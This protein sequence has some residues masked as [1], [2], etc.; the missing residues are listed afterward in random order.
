MLIKTLIDSFLTPLNCLAVKRRET[1]CS[2]FMP[3]EKSEDTKLTPQEKVA[4]VNGLCSA[5]AEA[6]F[7]GLPILVLF[8]V[9]HYK[10]LDS[11]LLA[12]PEWSFAAAVLFGL[13][14]VKLVGSI[15]STGGGHGERI[16]FLCALLLVLG[17]VPSLIV[18]ALV[19]LADSPSAW[20]TW[21]QIGLCILGG[22][23]FFGCA[24]FA[25]LVR[26]HYKK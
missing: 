12:S 5:G 3:S 23:I 22:V 24:G 10:Q 4:L 25:A 2:G 11:E 14:L 15:A 20:L 26:L 21:L 7:I 6:L 13:G 17:L 1:T 8:I 16:G 18:L 19:L 9:L